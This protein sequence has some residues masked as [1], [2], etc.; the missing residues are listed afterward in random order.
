[1]RVY[2]HLKKGALL[3]SLAPLKDVMETKHIIG[4]ASYYRNCITKRRTELLIGVY[5]V[6]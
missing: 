6:K 1:M 2:T 3:V 4:L 5:C